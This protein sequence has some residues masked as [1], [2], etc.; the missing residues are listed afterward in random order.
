MSESTK[1]PKKRRYSTSLIQISRLLYPSLNSEPSHSG[2]TLPSD[3]LTHVASFLVVRDLV[4]ALRINRAWTMAANH[5]SLW[6]ELFRFTWTAVDDNHSQTVTTSCDSKTVDAISSDETESSIA[7][8]SGFYF[9]EIPAHFV[10]ESATTH[11]RD[12]VKHRHETEQRWRAGKFQ[13]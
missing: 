7:K 6:K 4:S 2:T 13:R 11:W 12:R 5:D 3:L 8:I 1:Q 10:S 9:H